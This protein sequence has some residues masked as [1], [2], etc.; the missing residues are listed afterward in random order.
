MLRS[1]DRGMLLSMLRPTARRYSRV[2][3][4]RH[5]GRECG[6]DVVW[7]ENI[8]ELQYLLKANALQLVLMGLAQSFILPSRSRR[9]QM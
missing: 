9:C 4:I 8:V 1:G 5:S 3:T 2:Q 7:R 6:E